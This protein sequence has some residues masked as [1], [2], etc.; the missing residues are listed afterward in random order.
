M[1]RWQV[2]RREDGETAELPLHERPTIDGERDR[3]T[4]ANVG[5]NRVVQVRPQVGE[6]RARSA[7]E[8]EAAVLREERPQWR[9][10][11]VLREVATVADQ[12]EGARVVVRYGDHLDADHRCPTVMARVRS[13]DQ[14]ARRHALEPEGTRTVLGTRRK[15]SRRPTYGKNRKVEIRDEGRVRLRQPDVERVS[16]FDLDRTNPLVGVSVRRPERLAARAQKRRPDILRGH[17]RPVVKDHAGPEADAPVERTVPRNRLRGVGNRPKRPSVDPDE[18]RVEEA[19]ELHA[20]RI[21][22]EARVQ[23][24][25]LGA[26][27]K[28]DGPVRWQRRV[29][30]DEDRDEPERAAHAG[31]LRC[32]AVRRAFLVWILPVVLAR[33]ARGQDRDRSADLSRRLSAVFSDLGTSGARVGAVFL[34]VVSGRSLFAH[35]PDDPL[36]PASN[37][38]VLTAAAALSVLGPEHRFL[39]GVYGRLEAGTVAGSVY[40]RGFGDPVLDMSDLVA[41]ALELRQAGVRRVDGGVVVDGGF[42]DDEV[43]PPAFDQQPEED[44]PFRAPV[45]AVSVNRNA[46]AIRVSPAAEDGAPAIVTSVPPGYLVVD[47]RATTGGA[48]SLRIDVEPHDERTRARVWGT[49]AAG[50]RGAVYYKR[51][52]APLLFAG[53]AFREALRGAGI[54][55]GESVTTG[56]VAGEAEMLASH[57][58]PPLSEILLEMGKDSDNFV[59]EMVFKAA[60]AEA[61]G[62]PATARKAQRVVRDVLAGWHVPA[63]GLQ[64][65]NGSGLFDANRVTARQLAVVVRTMVQ[66]PRLGPEFIS[67]LATGGV[68]GTLRGRFTDEMSRRVV[69]AKTGTLETVSTLT[70]VVLAPPG[71]SPVAFSVL[72]NR[73]RGGLGNARRLQDSLVL[74][75]VRNLHGRPR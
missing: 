27:E 40:L 58:S 12:P 59:A 22:A 54:R 72:V 74:E 16:P 60:G 31:M 71:R 41:L 30:R 13:E 67:E 45:A 37:Q 44:A 43:L 61:F 51:I 49:V 21:G 69:R 33:H 53:Y 11:R 52:D 8:P 18:R 65:R 17:L 68:D 25:G 42:F 19:G 35:E 34:D 63:A 64:V 47:N 75:V 38:K 14:M 23:R 66:D 26:D 20:E 7:L 48:T 15:A 10:Q 28:P 1:S 2:A 29:A 5:E 9:G 32:R 36:N 4:D 50:T 46:V 62:R 55:C 39:T 70:G 56:G 73:A 3:A 6:R 24:L 57:R